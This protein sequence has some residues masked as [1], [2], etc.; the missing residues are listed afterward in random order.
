MHAWKA[1]SGCKA[2]HNRFIFVSS[3]VFRRF[4][5]WTINSLLCL[6]ILSPPSLDVL[7]KFASLAKRPSSK[8]L[9]SFGCL[10]L[11]RRLYNVLFRVQIELT[12]SFLSKE[13]KVVYGN[14]SRDN[15]RK[16]SGASAVLGH[17]EKTI[18]ATFALL[19]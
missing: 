6:L 1:S 19:W 15:D 3:K 9:T 14:R 16:R 8:W 12:L 18:G 13:S 5:S 2:I 17:L 4:I 10:F 7:Y 11:T